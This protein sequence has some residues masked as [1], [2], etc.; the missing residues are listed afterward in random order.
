MFHLPPLIS[1]LY[2][3]AATVFVDL[4]MRIHCHV[5]GLQVITP[6]VSQEVVTRIEEER[7]EVRGEETRDEIQ[8]N[9]G[10]T[11][12]CDVNGDLDVFEVDSHVGG[13]LRL[14]IEGISLVETSLVVAYHIKPF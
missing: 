13:S 5:R 9:L 2:L 14:I 10:R 6:S 7:D 4:Y 3:L 11:Q 1:F 12:T 8:F